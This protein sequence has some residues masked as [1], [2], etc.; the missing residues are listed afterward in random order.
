MG[1]K[2]VVAVDVSMGGDFLQPC[3][4]RSEDLPLGYL[5]SQA[6][7]VRAAVRMLAESS[8]GDFERAIQ[9]Q[10]VSERQERADRRRNGS[11]GE[12]EELSRAS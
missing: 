2:R 12:V 10:A 7:L 5:C 6:V 3:L 8:D 1:A 4:R 11:G 9:R